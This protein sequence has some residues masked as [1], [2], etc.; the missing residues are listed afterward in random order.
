[1]KNTPILSLSDI[2]S[3]NEDY[4][5]INS[6]SSHFKSHF[7]IIEKA[8]KHDFYFCV[9]FKEGI[10]THEIDFKTYNIKPRSL[11]LLRPGQ[12]H[13]W[14]F[15]SPPKGY[16]LLHTK[17]FIEF[18]FVKEY[19][20]SYPFYKFNK[21]PVLYLTKEEASNIEIY[22][23]KL[24][25]EFSDNK[26]YKN[27]ILNA[28]VKIIYIEAARLFNNPTTNKKHIPSRYFKVLNLLESMIEN[29]FKTKKNA[30]FYSN[31]LH[32]TTKHLNRIVNNTLSK[33]TSEIIN[34][35]VI[36]EA[37]RLI[38]HTNYT[39][40]YISEELGYDDYA[41]FS[42]FF[43]SKTDFTPSQFKNKYKV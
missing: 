30:S 21:E 4:F 34:E 33:T 12:I 3:N 29:D 19:L 9:F 41:Y 42:R 6:L 37:K 11:F 35:R 25:L 39:L 14:Q 22:Y 40:K 43:K 10:G 13:S 28:F 38:A 5:Y 16:I 31:E 18:P 2:F 36:L 23:E 26:I 24:F 17:E 1:M 20:E 32:I 27:E 15:N 8:H 7:K